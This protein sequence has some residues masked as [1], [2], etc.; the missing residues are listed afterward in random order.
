MCNIFKEEVTE[1]G[2]LRPVYDM[3]PEKMKN[4]VMHVLEENGQK[5]Y[6]KK[7]KENA[8]RLRMT[9]LDYYADK[10]ISDIKI[11]KSVQYLRTNET[12]FYTK[13]I[14]SDPGLKVKY[15]FDDKRKL[16]YVIHNEKKLYF[17]HDMNKKTV[18]ATYKALLNEQNVDSPHLYLRD[19]YKKK[20][21]CCVVDAGASEGIF[22]LDIID[23]CDKLYI[24]E[25]DGSW[26][27][28]LHATFHPYRSKVVF[29][30]KYLGDKIGSDVISL[31]ELL[32]KE[33]KVDLIKMDIEGAEPSALIG[34]ETILARNEQCCLLVCV[35]HYQNEEKDVDLILSDYKK[36]YRDSYVI[37][38]HDSNQQVPYFRNGVITYYK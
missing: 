22:S 20:K 29:C 15:G 35:Y 16:P 21:Y 8:S 23:H 11:K 27:E 2:I 7:V 30:N 4:Y 9:I 25:C 31:D 32:K 33:K 28:A 5:K 13:R 3:M 12:D 37:F 17:R 34:G 24:V 36:E 1:M 19:K 14:V 6:A 38:P 18:I 26:N 10:E